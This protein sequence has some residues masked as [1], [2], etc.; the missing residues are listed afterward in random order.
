MIIMQKKCVI[1]YW[2]LPLLYVLWSHVF[3]VVAYAVHIAVMEQPM[4]W[5]DIFSLSM[6][7]NGIFFFISL[8]NI[9]FLYFCLYALKY[10]G[11]YAKILTCGLVLLY[12]LPMCLHAVD[13]LGEVSSVYIV[14][15]FFIRYLNYSAIFVFAYYIYQK[16][17]MKYC[18]VKYWSLISIGFIFCLFWY[19][20]G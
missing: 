9:L 2:T 14:W 12:P 3:S 19:L 11:R 18:K 7:E 4:S 1:L 16:T 8:V 13:A 5:R 20:E 6:F 15:S 10:S 17:D